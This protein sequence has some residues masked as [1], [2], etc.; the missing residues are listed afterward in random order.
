MC[1]VYKRV[2]KE[3]ASVRESAD[4]RL[5]SQIGDEDEIVVEEVSHH[6]STSEQFIILNH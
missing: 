3:V 4:G 2:C 5:Q 6:P 1:R